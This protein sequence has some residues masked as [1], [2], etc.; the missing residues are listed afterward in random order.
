MLIA[1]LDT[2]EALRYRSLLHKSSSWTEI[3]FV[4]LCVQFEDVLLEGIRD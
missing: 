3:S 1:L 4:A 2:L